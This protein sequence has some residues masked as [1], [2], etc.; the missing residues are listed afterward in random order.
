MIY[1]K[2]DILIQQFQYHCTTWTFLFQNSLKWGY[3]TTSCLRNRKSHLLECYFTT[4]S[5][6]AR[7]FIFAKWSRFQC[8]FPSLASSLFPPPRS[9]FVFVPLFHLCISFFFLLNSLPPPLSQTRS[10]TTVNFSGKFR[11]WRVS[12]IVTSSPCLL[13]ARPQHLTTS[14]PSWWRK[15]AC[16]TS[17]EVNLSVPLLSFVRKFIYVRVRALAYG[18]L[19]FACYGVM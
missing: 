19:L 8:W 10:W 13:S 11:S 12:A 15:A 14:S 5:F 16:S 1:W 3:S 7:S 2:R 6:I 18:W 17:S 4:V 9:S